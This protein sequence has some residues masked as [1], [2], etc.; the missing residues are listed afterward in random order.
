MDLKS[1]YIQVTNIQVHAKP[2]SSVGYCL[3]DC[4]ALAA[5]EWQN[6]VLKH[7]DE[8]YLI[9]VNDLLAS[10]QQPKKETKREKGPLGAG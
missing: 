7:N 1:E 2:G 6:V 9:H 4:I 8:E 10:V 5:T 3:R